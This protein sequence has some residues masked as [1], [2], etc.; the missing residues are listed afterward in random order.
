[1]QTFWLRVHGGP[2]PKQAYLVRGKRLKEHMV[3][4]DSNLFQSTQY[5]T[6][7]KKP[8]TSETSFSGFFRMRRLPLFHMVLGTEGKARITEGKPKG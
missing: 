3:A 4:S 2:G 1:M 7:Y 5:A 8:H 6:V